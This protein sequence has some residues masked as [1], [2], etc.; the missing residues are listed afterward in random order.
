[1]DGLPII[2]GLSH[3]ARF[4]H[5]ARGANRYEGGMQFV[6]QEDRIIVYIVG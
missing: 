6:P 2:R 5:M 3:Q 4:L 1:M